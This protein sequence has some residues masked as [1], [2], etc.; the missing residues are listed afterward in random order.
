MKYTVIFAIFALSA[1]ATK[2]V[3]VADV[4][5]SS[6][7][8]AAAAARHYANFIASTGASA[9]AREQHKQDVKRAEIAAHEAEN[10]CTLAQ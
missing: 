1:C 5:V 3:Q 8:K 4:H 2:T 7:C 10:R 9:F 6:Q